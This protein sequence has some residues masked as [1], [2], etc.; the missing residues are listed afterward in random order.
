MGRRERGKGRE[1][2]SEDRALMVHWFG[3][4]REECVEGYPLDEQHCDG[5]DEDGGSPQASLTPCHDAYVQTFMIQCYTF[6]P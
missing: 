1:N 3:V 5:S 2:T 6:P 4:I